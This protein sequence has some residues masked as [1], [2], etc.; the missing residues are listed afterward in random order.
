LG[1]ELCGHGDR[2]ERPHLS[3]PRRTRLPWVWICTS[4]VV[5]G[6]SVAAAAAPSLVEDINAAVSPSPLAPS[7]LSSVNGTLFFYAGDGIHGRE[8]WKS[9]GT[10]SGTVMVKDI[11]IGTGDSIIGWFTD[12]N[13]KVLF[14]AQDAAH[15]AEL[16]TTN[17]TAAGT[18]LFKDINLG[19]DS[20]P[21]YLTV[22]N[23]VLFFSAD[24]GTHGA[25]LWKSDGTAAGT[26]MVKDINPGTGNSLS[27]PELTALNGVLYFFAYDGV[28][29]PT[30][31]K[32]DGT[33]AGTFMWASRTPVPACLGLTRR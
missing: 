33:A 21:G 7:T 24:D 4:L 25:E 2:G 10:P 31:W 1:Q 26:V 14:R 20:N 18:V 27:F 32:S 13:G 5:L 30:L 17:G 22:L 11:N 28:H 16:W 6:T 29:H 12:L 19:G 3:S 23:G 15:G 9:D 8:I